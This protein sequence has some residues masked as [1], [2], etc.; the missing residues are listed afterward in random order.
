MIHGD[1]N[2]QNVLVQPADDRDDEFDISGVTDFEDCVWAPYVFE[3]IILVCCHFIMSR[4]M[5]NRALS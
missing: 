2:Q 4:S 3:V 5:N 1:Y